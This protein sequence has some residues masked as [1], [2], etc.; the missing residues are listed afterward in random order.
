M[1]YNLRP[2]AAKII[3]RNQPLPGSRSKEL[4]FDVEIR[5]NKKL[6]H[7]HIVNLHEVYRAP[8][9]VLICTCLATASHTTVNFINRKI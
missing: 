5:I 9:L 1:I 4:M 7:E 2:D 8:T 3:K 6:N